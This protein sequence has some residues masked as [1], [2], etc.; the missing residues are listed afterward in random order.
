MIVISSILFLVV[1]ILVMMAINITK[2]NERA[3]L[4]SDQ[5][6]LYLR[7]S[8]LLMI[9]WDLVPDGEAVCDHYTVF[10]KEEVISLLEK[11]VQEN[12][13]ELWKVYDTPSGGC[14]AFLVSHQYTPGKG[15]AILAEM[16]GD[17]LYR[18]MCL[19]RGKWSV[20]VSPKPNRAGD[21][22]ASR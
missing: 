4:K 5:G 11:R 18:R 9:D 14:H 10:S 2:K 8:K 6:T 12:P 1:I 13:K 16:R 7:M 21:Y 20:R 3:S 22:E 19:W 15:E 17:D